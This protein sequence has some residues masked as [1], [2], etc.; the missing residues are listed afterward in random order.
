MVKVGGANFRFGSN[1]CFAP[2]WLR[3]WFIL[4]NLVGYFRWAL[5]FLPFA[6]YTA[7]NPDPQSFLHNYHTEL[8][9]FVGLHTIKVD[10]SLRQ[11]APSS[12]Q[13]QDCQ[14]L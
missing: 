2:R 14:Q 7:L 5:P 3:P 11:T 10:I 6:G 4:P 13:R 12:C 9:H 8:C 1:F